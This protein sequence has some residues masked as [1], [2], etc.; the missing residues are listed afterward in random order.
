VKS[1]L[2]T[3]QCGARY[4]ARPLASFLVYDFISGWIG[5]ISQN[6]IDIVSGEGDPGI[7]PDLILRVNVTIGEG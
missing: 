7:G 1:I 4:A 5:E 2:L 3:S 6:K